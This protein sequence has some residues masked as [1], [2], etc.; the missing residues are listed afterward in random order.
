MREEPEL[1]PGRKSAW[2]D[3]D[4][5]A[6][7]I[8]AFARDAQEQET[9][10]ATLVEIVRAAVALVPGCD[11]G[12]I[13]LVV[14]RD[15]VTS[16]AASGDLPR[17]VDALQ[18]EYQEGPCLDAAF[19]HDTV[20]V[21]DLAAEVRWPRF[22]PG[23]VDAGIAGM[24]CFQLYVEGDNLGALNLLAEQPDAFTDESVHVGEMLATHAAVAYASSQQH[25]KLTRSVKTQQLIGQAQGILMERHKISD[26][27]AFAVLVRASQQTN[28]KLRELASRLVLSGELGDQDGQAG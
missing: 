16:E 2:G 12:S 9:P 10:H 11:G 26:S 3:P 28:V 21:D 14:G 22:G 17:L 18:E 6:S 25:S 27:Q 5:L 23:A 19:R 13:S 8:S 1:G 20:R 24:L 15:K 7:L 4:L